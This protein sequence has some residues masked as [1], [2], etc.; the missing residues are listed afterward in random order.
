LRDSPAG[1]SNKIVEPG[2]VFEGQVHYDKSGNVMGY[3][4]IKNAQKIRVGEGRYG[5]SVTISRLMCQPKRAAQFEHAESASQG[6]GQVAPGEGV[7]QGPLAN[8][9]DNGEFEGSF[10]GGPLDGFGSQGF[11]PGG[12][13]APGLGGP[14]LGGP[15]GFGAPGLGIA[16]GLGGDFAGLAPP[17]APA[18]GPAL[19][20]IGAGAG[21]G[22]GC[23]TGET[24]VETP[25]GPKRM[26]ELKIGD[27]V[28]AVM[29]D[30]VIGF[31]PIK[32]FLH[33]LP[34]QDAEFHRITAGGSSVSLTP[35]H[36]IYTT[37]CDQ[38][39]PTMKYA[40][41][42]KPEAECLIRIYGEKQIPVRVQ[43][44]EVFK[45]TGIYNPMTE[46]GTIVA[47]G[48]MASI[49]NVFEDTSFMNT[50][51]ETVQNLQK[52]ISGEHSDNHVELPWALQYAIDYANKLF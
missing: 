8:N 19:G 9:V 35:L 25:S 18:V 38:V 24:M 47:D 27:Q 6:F 21:G 5:M 33:R 16:P 39:T 44:N 51:M 45:S 13:G 42:V 26:D 43:S 40:R 32:S 2:Q 12:L 50:F 41:D 30:R 4:I 1:E 48:F 34:N 15:G 11:G 49:H 7:F 52:L 22:G 17:L 14:G 28:L 23:F 3:D 46:A 37:P 10:Q 36:Y 20:A 29:H 31:S